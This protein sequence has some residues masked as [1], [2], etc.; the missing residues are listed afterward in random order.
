VTERAGRAGVLLTRRQLVGFGVVLVLLVAAFVVQAVRAGDPD[1]A[2]ERYAPLRKVAALEPCPSGLGRGLPDLVLPCLGGGDDVRMR[3][4]GPGVPL[5]VNAWGSW[6]G[7]CKREVPELVEL[8]ARGKGRLGLVGVL[9]QDDVEK[10]LTFAKDAGMRYPSLVDDDGAF[11][12]KYAAG[13]PVTLFVT[14]GGDIAHVE[15]GEISS[16]EE[17]LQLVRTHLGVVL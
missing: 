9:T 16:L 1:P 2:V 4:D 13:P 3:D 7:P 10:G 15:R 5:L 6:C 12:R 14:A 11:F 17:M 8:A